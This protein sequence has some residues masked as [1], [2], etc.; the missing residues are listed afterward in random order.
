MLF[1]KALFSIPFVF[2]IACAGY[3]GDPNN[4]VVVQ[5]KVQSAN[6]LDI[7]AATRN[8]GQPRYYGDRLILIRAADLVNFRKG[9]QCT[10][11]NQLFQ[12]S[13][14]APAYVKVPDYRRQSPSATIRCSY[15]GKIGVDTLEAINI[16]EKRRAANSMMGAG[17]GIS[18]IIPI[19]PRERA[20]DIWGYPEVFNVVME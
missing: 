19:G 4:V 17:G 7:Y 13:F 20:D 16:S 5:P 8:Q 9:P 1:R 10:L 12:A 2:L 3:D 6:G 11:S 14:T 15:E 18:I